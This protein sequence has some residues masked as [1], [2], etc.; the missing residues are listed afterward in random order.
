MYA[1]LL[2]DEVGRSPVPFWRALPD[3]VDTRLLPERADER[4]FVFGPATSSVR[5]RVLHRRFWA[6]TTHSKGWP[7]GDMIVIYYTRTVPP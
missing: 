5:V 3:A 7:D 2:R 4:R 1:R 6:E